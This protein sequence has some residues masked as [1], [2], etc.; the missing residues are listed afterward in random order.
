MFPLNV[1]HLLKTDKKTQS[2]EADSASAWWSMSFI[3]S[4][5]TD[6]AEGL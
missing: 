4:G 2:E 5:V 3:Y 6:A 1:S